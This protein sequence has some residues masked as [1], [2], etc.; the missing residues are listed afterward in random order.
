MR[1]FAVCGVGDGG[2]IQTL[3]VGGGKVTI[4]TANGYNLR[5]YVDA[6]APVVRI[7]GSHAKG[8]T[9]KAS[10]KETF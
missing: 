10:Y 1:C 8:F 5:V 9:V 3:D 7:A 6:N 4:K 2:F